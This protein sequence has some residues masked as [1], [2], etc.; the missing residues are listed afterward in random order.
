MIQK[1]QE[2]G[3]SDKTV[4]WQWIRLL[5]LLSWWFSMFSDRLVAPKTSLSSTQL[6]ATMTDLLL[7]CMSLL[8]S[9]IKNA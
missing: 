3:D 6:F 5:P 1:K 2:T 9:M 8:L 4:F 7:V